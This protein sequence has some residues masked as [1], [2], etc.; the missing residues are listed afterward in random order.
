MTVSPTAKAYPTHPPSFI[1]QHR[2]VDENA[3]ACAGL[4]C[5]GLNCAL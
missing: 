4:N 5:E 1:V 3:D 2:D